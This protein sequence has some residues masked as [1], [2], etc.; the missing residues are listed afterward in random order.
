MGA[1]LDP[2]R[3]RFARLATFCSSSVAKVS[4]CSPVPGA[5]DR[6]PGRPPAHP[7][8]LPSVGR[9]PSHRVCTQSSGAK[10]L[11]ASCRKQWETLGRDPKTTRPGGSSL[12]KVEK[13]SCE[14]GG[15]LSAGVL[16]S[17][18]N[19]LRM[20]FKSCYKKSPRLHQNI[21][22]STFVYHSVCTLK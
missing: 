12:A 2:A 3:L 21:K 22:S 4:S 11:R 19:V 9:L 5:S 10:R 13:A 15:T 17:C 18:L 7:A 8:G 16:S 6:L 1:R 14:A 20:N